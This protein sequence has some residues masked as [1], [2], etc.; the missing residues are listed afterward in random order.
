ML[1]A[2]SAPADAA[3]LSAAGPAGA[4]APLLGARARRELLL[5]RLTARPVRALLARA[6]A[7]GSRSRGPAQ[8]HGLRAGYGASLAAVVQTVALIGPARVNGPLTQALNAPVVGRLQARG[9]P[10]PRGSAPA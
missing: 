5:P 8:R 9:R 3:T 1:A 4:G 7:A 2:A 10:V 6:S